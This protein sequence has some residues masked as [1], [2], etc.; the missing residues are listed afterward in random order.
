MKRLALALV[1]A[2]A[3]FGCA[4][5]ATG[6]RS[7]AES[8]SPTVSAATPS[9][10]SSTAAPSP[11]AAGQTIDIGGR[12]LY[13]ECLGTGSPTVI[14]EAGLTGDHRTWEQV[15]PSLA[16]S[17]RVCAY[18]RANIPPSDPGPNPRSAQD[19]VDDLHALLDEAGVEAPYVLVGFSI[20]GLISQLYA[21]SYPDEVSGL[22]LVESS[23]PREAEQFEEHLTADQ[24]TE[25]RAA[26]LDN[27]EGFDPFASFEEVQAAGALP[28]VPLVVVTAGISEGW[29]PG[30]DAELFDRL[31]AE[32]QADLATLIPGG[33]QVV[34]ERSAHH[35]PS[36]QPEVIIEAVES[37][38]AAAR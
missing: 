19:A 33:R 2:V 24:I 16:A 8:G 27:P 5:T 26:T 6:G 30:W 31:R 17:T 34:A 37:V 25:D 18:D 12:E 35:V 13:L 29:P 14:L 38:L 15:Q 32:Q 11:T 22:V 21:A 10:S 9:P 23:H 36:Q 7:G 20:G 1:S 4:A 28:E 3:V